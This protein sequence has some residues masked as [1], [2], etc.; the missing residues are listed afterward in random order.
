MFAAV[1]IQAGDR[2]G[3]FGDAKALQRGKALF[4][5]GLDVVFGDVVQHIPQGFVAGQEED[6]KAVRLEH[7]QRIRR[8]GECAEDFSVA[9]EGD[10]CGA[11]GFLV[12][13][14][15]GDGIRLAAHGELDALLDVVKSSLAAHGLDSAIR[16]AG[17]INVGKVDQVQDAGAVVAVGGLLHDIDP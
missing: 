1:G 2:H 14:G 15:R 16:E 8:A 7:G 4:D 13:R 5:A 10:L 17:L 6:A 12:D 3:A 9:Y 11:Q